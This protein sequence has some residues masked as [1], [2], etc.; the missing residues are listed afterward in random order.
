MSGHPRAGTTVPAP[1][2]PQPPATSGAALREAMSRFATGITVLTTGGEQVHGMTANSFTSVSL[3]PPLVLCCVARTAVMHQAITTTRS[4]A[5]SVLGA[6]QEQLARYFASRDRPLGAAQFHG[7]DWQPGPLTGAP[8]LGKAVARLECKLAEAYDG[9]DHSIFL[10]EVLASDWNTG[11]DA[12]LFYGGG[13][14]RVGRGPADR[15]G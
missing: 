7:L 12:L 15:N 3:E 13:F 10:G 11:D 8:L 5:V 4:F 14:H 6:E 2:S 1:R 9:G